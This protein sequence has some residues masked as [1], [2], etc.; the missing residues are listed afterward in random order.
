MVLLA[1]TSAVSLTESPTCEGIQR[2]RQIFEGREGHKG[3]V[4]SELRDCVYKGIPKACAGHFGS[5]SI[6]RNYYC[7]GTKFK[8]VGRKYKSAI[9]MKKLKEER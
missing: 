7:P 1:K 5:Q 8:K 4:F 2:R 9:K 6:G 3:N